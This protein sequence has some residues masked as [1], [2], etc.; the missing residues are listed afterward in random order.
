MSVRISTGNKLN[1]SSYVPWEE[2]DVCVKGTSRMI[3]VVFPVI[4][5]IRFDCNFRDTDYTKNFPAQMV[6]M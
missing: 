1:I 2:V 3:L 5:E 4:D 6:S